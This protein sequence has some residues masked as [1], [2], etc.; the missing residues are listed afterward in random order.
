MNDMRR[1]QDEF[2]II[3]Q[4]CL[5]LIESGQET[6]DSVLSRYPDLAEEL[7]PEL[8]MAFWIQSK[9]ES[10]EPRPGFVSSSRRR[11]LERIQQESQQTKARDPLF[12]WMSWLK[13][14]PVTIAVIAV[15]IVSLISVSG[16]AVLA[17][18]G[19]LPGDNLYPLKISL[20]KAALAVTVNQTQNAQLSVQFTERRSAEIYQMV[21]EGR[22]DH[23]NDSVANFETQ[24]NSTIQTLDVVANNNDQQAQELA[25]SLKIILTNQNEFLSKL[26]ITAPG[27]A[28][29]ALAKA[30]RVTENGVTAA[31]VLIKTPPPPA[32]EEATFTPLAPWSPTPSLTP[33]PT[34]TWAPPWTPTSAPT[35]A[36]L[37][38]RTKSPT[39]TPYPTLPATKTPEP[40]NTPTSTPKPTRTEPPPTDTPTPTETP[41]PTPTETPT[42]TPTQTP[43]ETPTSTPTETPTVTIAPTA[44]ITPTITAT[45]FVGISTPLVTPPSAGSLQPKW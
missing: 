23:I 8:E 36:P 12:T 16:G 3:L 26:I 4:S 21:S 11:L 20:E 24:V 9:T 1:N 17:A 25:S 34:N 35:E 5:E 37:P 28:K 31:D 18:Q 30:I 10:L 22:Y 2:D 15:L 7:R 40:A 27:T 19:S 29:P 6:I 44:S 43:T 45:L 38:T 32:P 14:A 39:D 41:T 33:L 13:S 42:A